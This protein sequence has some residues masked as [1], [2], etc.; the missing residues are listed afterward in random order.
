MKGNKGITLT[1]LIIYVVAMLIVVSLISVLTGYFYQ[2]VEISSESDQA[3]KQ[4]TQFNSYFSN[5]IAKSSIKVIETEILGTEP[6]RTSYITFSNKNTYTFSE[7]TKSIYRNDIRI[8]NNIDLCL[9]RYEL[10][11]GKY[12]IHIDF[13]SGTFTRTG[14][15]AIVYNIK[16]Q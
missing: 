1:S 6:K 5:D 16:D 11:D 9:F 3:M 2:N 14:D 12:V 13:K 15:H 7:E 8:G 10:Q 4:Y